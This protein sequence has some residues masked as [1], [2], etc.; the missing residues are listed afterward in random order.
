MTALLAVVQKLE[1]LEEKI[2]DIP[3]AVRESR[4][5]DFI[6]EFEKLSLALMDLFK[7]VEDFS[8]KR[9]A[10]LEHMKTTQL[11]YQ[12]CG[13]QIEDVIQATKAVKESS[14]QAVA[15]LQKSFKEA[16]LRFAEITIL[17]VDSGF[18]KMHFD[19]LAEQIAEDLRANESEK[20]LFLS[21]ESLSRS[22]KSVIVADQEARWG[23][24][25]WCLR[26]ADWMSDKSGSDGRHPLRQVSGKYLFTPVAADMLLDWAKAA[27]DDVPLKF[28][29]SLKDLY[30]QISYMHRKFAS[31]GLQSPDEQ[32]QFDADWERM[33]FDFENIRKSYAMVDSTERAVVGKLQL[34][35][36]LLD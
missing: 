11:S 6:Y 19:A 36:R 1:V 16:V 24:E 27:L 31:W 33:A 22:L 17:A 15:L 3:V 5:Q 30:M 18:S 8:A 9:R 10:D 7:Q 34:S 4:F 2:D 21:H 35:S 14:A 20:D 23:F 29:I 26:R 12:S 13:S 28:S 25:F 32:K